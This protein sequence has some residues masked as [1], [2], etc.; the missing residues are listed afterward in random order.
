M[1]RG[2]VRWARPRSPGRRSSPGRRARRRTSRRTPGPPVA[3][4]GASVPP[5]DAV[6]VVVVTYSPGEA[7]D[8]FLDT[9]EKATTRPYRVVLAD[10]GSTD[11]APER[12]ALRSRL[13]LLRTG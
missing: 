9:L 13:A 10:N 12:A 1:R 8:R 6:G 5:P 7:L 2:A 4:R 3:D 11:G